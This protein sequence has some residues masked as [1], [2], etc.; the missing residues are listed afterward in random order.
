MNSVKILLLSIALSWVI[1][2]NAQNSDSLMQE[3]R[4]M[5]KE[6]DPAVSLGMMKGMIEKY[7]LREAKDSETLDML[8]GIVA[9]DYLEA[10]KYKEF[11]KMIASIQN[12]F[13]QTSYLNMAAATLLKERKDLKK[14]GSLAKRAL[15][16]YLSIRDDPKA[17]PAGY[18]EADW[19]RFMKFAY[20]P[21]TDTYANALYALG[22]YKEALKYQ[23]KVFDKSPEN[24]MPASVERY[25]HLLLLNNQSERAYS[26]L[27]EMAK[28]G[29]S[30]AGMN[31]L[32]KELYVKSKGDESGFDSF[33]TDLQKNVV[34]ALKEKLKKKMQ[35]TI[36]PGFT[37][38]DLE[39]N[40]VSLSDFK[41]K[42]VVIDFWATWCAPCKASFPAMQKALQ[43]HP[44]VKFLFI[45][46]QEKQEGAVERVKN[47]IVQSRYPFH[48]LMDQPLPDNSQIFQVMTLY[49]VQG[50]PTKFVIDTKGRQRFASVG[51]TSDT[52]LINEMEAMIQLAAEHS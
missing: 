37:L 18:P 24:G 27:L 8:K 9:M 52:E 13:N 4:L 15:D 7:H 41:G 28:T 35:D 50:I 22:K 12:R 23:E 46:T 48:V 31:K 3:V 29:K 39:G 45:D 49:K 14:A 25:A 38:K 40:N 11:D 42:I 33:F 16:L 10:G 20:Y 36:A 2:A 17:K 6:T 1:C 21:Y 26:L 44:E 30:T 19:K 34:V 51:F 43:R 47:Y 5:A 32:L